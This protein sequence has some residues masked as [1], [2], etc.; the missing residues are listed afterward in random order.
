MA[1]RL[2]YKTFQIKNFPKILK[3]CSKLASSGLDKHISLNKQ[4]H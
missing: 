2:Y 4:K 1:R 3:N